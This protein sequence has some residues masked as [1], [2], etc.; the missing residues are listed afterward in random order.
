METKIIRK[1]Q[2]ASLNKNVQHAK[3]IRYTT[4]KNTTIEY[5]YKQIRQHVPC[6]KKKKAW[7]DFD[8]PRS[9]F[10]QIQV[11]RMRPKH[12][13]INM[14]WLRV[15]LPMAQ[16]RIRNL[17]YHASTFAVICARGRKSRLKKFAKIEKS[18]KI[19][20]SQKC[21]KQ[22]TLRIIKSPHIH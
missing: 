8:A 2:N 13:P 3:K 10:C 7:K 9:H 5:M 22:A 12:K 18:W 19:E 15:W 1:T 4:T 6:V 20:K 17:C 16:I 14:D 11:K 21:R